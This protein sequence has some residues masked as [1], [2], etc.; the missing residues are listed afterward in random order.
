MKLLRPDLNPR[1]EHPVM[2][3]AF[4]PTLDVERLQQ[5]HLLEQFQR[6]DGAAS[7]QGRLSRSLDALLEV[8][9]EEASHW[10]VSFLC[11]LCFGCT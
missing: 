4:A 5:P 2:F 6:A 3:V 10:R 9:V 8:A 11:P 1:L 7:F